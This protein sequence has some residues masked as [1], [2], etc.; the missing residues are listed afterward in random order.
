MKDNRPILSYGAVFRTLYA[1]DDRWSAGTGL[2]YA[3]KG[4]SFGSFSYRDVSTG[5]WRETSLTNA[6]SFL[7]VPL[8]IRYFFKER[9][10]YRLYAQSGLAASFFLRERLEMPDGE[11]KYVTVE[12]SSTIPVNLGLQAGVGVLV[13]LSGPWQIGVEPTLNSH[14]LPAYGDTPVKMWLF[15]FGINLL[16]NRAW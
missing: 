5:I 15:S 14:L 4:F 1:V 11:L 12:N 10:N 3:R 2:G 13:P 8:F 16:V 9:E 6:Y 7:E